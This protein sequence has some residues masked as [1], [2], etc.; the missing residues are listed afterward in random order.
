MHAASDPKAGKFLASYFGTE[1]ST[2]FAGLTAV[3]ARRVAVR[4][5]EHFDRT[6]LRRLLA[7]DA[8][9]CRFVALE[10]MVRQYEQHPAARETL[11]KF[12]LSNLGHVDH[13][14]LVDTSASYI[15]GD[16]LRD[17]PRTPLYRLARSKR[18]PERR[19]AIVATWAFIKGGD[20]AD[21]LRIAEQLLDDESKLIHRAVGWMLREVGKRSP[22]AIEKFLRTHAR[23]MPS[24]MLRCAV[25]RLPRSKPSY[26][27]SRCDEPSKTAATS[28]S[29][30]SRP[31]ARRPAH[32]PTG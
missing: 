5:A 29:A 28:S 10:I 23:S 32:H 13:W 7:S 25:K 1:S 8:P 15:L 26:Y 14:V 20:F 22:I 24:L 4:F 2:P 3:A 18:M 17:K 31:R 6:Q 21:T 19:I 9:E 12:Y 27:L 16:Y 11:A 30:V